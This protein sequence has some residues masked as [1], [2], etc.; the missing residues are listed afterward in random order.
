MSCVANHTKLLE[1]VTRELRA[2][3]TS[4]HQQIISRK[5][6]PRK[7]SAINRQDAIILENLGSSC[8]ETLKHIK[9]LYDQT[10]YLKGVI[11]MI[12]DDLEK[13]S[14]STPSGIGR[15]KSGS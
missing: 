12:D 3:L 6:K 9:N 13:S 4:Y 2:E 5:A 15:T 1:G 11:N 10:R 8:A 7:Q 14:G